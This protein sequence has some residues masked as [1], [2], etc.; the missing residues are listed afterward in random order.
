MPSL[1]D[2]LAAGNQIVDLL[3]LEQPRSHA[4]KPAHTPPV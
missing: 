4:S 1:K 3:R 2:A